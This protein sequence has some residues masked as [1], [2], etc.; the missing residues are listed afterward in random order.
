MEV[1]FITCFEA[2]SHGVWLKSFIFCLKIMDSIARPLRIFYDNSAT[3]FLAKNNI[4]SSQSKHISVKFLT[5]RE[6]VKENKMVIK[7]I[8]IELMIADLSTK[9]IPPKS[10]KDHVDHMRLGFIM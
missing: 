5:I 10:Y 7:H 4:S 8:S 1:E 6:Y 3:A 2:T 9:I